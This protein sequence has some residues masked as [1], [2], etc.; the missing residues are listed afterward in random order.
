[1]LGLWVWAELVMLGGW[2]QQPLTNINTYFILK[3]LKS[4]CVKKEKKKVTPNLIIFLTND[5]LFPL[6]F[7]YI[8]FLVLR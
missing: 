7:F 6:L 4:K 3:R 2:V 8:S 5:P 1:M